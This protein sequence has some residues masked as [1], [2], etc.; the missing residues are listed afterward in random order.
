MD[1]LDRLFRLLTSLMESGDARADAAMAIALRGLVALLSRQHYS[2]SSSSS[3]GWA[4]TQLTAL[5]VLQAMA[6]QSAT[7]REAITAA[8]AVG[9]L[10]RLIEGAGVVTSGAV[11]VAAVQALQALV[12]AGSVGDIVEARGMAVLQGLAGSLSPGGE[13]WGAVRACLARIAA[14]Q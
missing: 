13:L 6:L 11:Q 3:E 10:V 1:A 9:P 8:G 4:E 14:A 12:V 2:S 5:T 7:Y